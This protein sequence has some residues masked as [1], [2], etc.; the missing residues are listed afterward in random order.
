M[1]T[2]LWKDAVLRH[3]LTRDEEGEKMWAV[4]QVKSSASYESERPESWVDAMQE[5]VKEYLMLPS[6]RV[7]F[8]LPEM[9]DIELVDLM[10]RLER[11]TQMIVPVLGDLFGEKKDHNGD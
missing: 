4:V 1:I 8:R 5:C 7:T 9:S 6:F 11:P 10:K 3:A 2:E